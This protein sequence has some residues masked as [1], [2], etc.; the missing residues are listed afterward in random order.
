MQLN[1]VVEVNVPANVT[2][3][4]IVVPPRDGVNEKAGSILGIR[5]SINAE[6]VEQVHLLFFKKDSAIA[7]HGA[8]AFLTS[9][10]TRCT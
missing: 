1:N 9:G 4:H 10:Y 5:P 2:D 7:S 3:V 6:N 8:C